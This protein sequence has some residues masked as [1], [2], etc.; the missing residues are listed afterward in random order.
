MTE[1]RLCAE[2]ARLKQRLT[3]RAVAILAVASGI[4]LGSL[5]FPPGAEWNPLMAVRIDTHT[6]IQDLEAAGANPKIA[7][8]VVAIISQADSRVATKSHV[9]AVVNKA[10][11]QIILAQLL[12]AGGAV[13]FLKLTA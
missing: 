6:A 12:I 8:A 5:R 10:I 1:T 11:V 13:A 2:P 4:Q 7:E 3:L 9:E